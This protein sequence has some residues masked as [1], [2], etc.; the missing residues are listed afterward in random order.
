VL[1]LDPVN[2][3]PF[4]KLLVVRYVTRMTVEQFRAI[5]ILEWD[6]LGY[7]RHPGRFSWRWTRH[8]QRTA[9]LKAENHGEFLGLKYSSQTADGWRAI[10]FKRQLL[11]ILLAP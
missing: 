5:N 3:S 10:R 11:P 7:L 8:H 4:A 9:F 1:R 6:R 2:H